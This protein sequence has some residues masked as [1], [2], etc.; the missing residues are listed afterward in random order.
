MREVV[1]RRCHANFL[2]LAFVSN[3]YSGERRRG[4]FENNELGRLGVECKAFIRLHD[5]LYVYESSRRREFRHHVTI[6]PC[7]FS[8]TRAVGLATISV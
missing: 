4:C 1:Q 3:D 8:L 2:D 6:L 5:V 7:E